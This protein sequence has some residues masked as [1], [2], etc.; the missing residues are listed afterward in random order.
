[1]RGIGLEM[2]LESWK[3]VKGRG[4]YDVARDGVEECVKLGREI[5]DVVYLVLPA[6]LNQPGV[7]I[8]FLALLRPLGRLVNALV[9]FL[10]A[11]LFRGVF[12]G[13]RMF[14]GRINGV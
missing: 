3:E 10:L 7:L 9:L 8:L 13:R 1:M 12:G 14:R 11:N 2:M 6:Q 5:C 4:R